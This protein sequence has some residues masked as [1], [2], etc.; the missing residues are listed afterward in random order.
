MVQDKRALFFNYLFW[1]TGFL[2]P[3]DQPWINYALGLLLLFFILQWLTGKYQIKIQNPL[4]WLPLSYFLLH[5]I[6]MI[7]TQSQYAGWIEIS[8]KS[9]FLI[10]PLLFS[11]NAISREMIRTFKLFFV[12]GSGIICLYNLLLSFNQYLLHGNMNSFYYVAFS[13][14]MHVQYLTIYLNLAILFIL[15]ILFNTSSQTNKIKKIFWVLLVLFFLINITLLASRLATVVSYVTILFYTVVR[16]ISSPNYIRY[17]VLAALFAASVLIIDYFAFKKINRFEQV[18]IFLNEKTNFVDFSKTEYNSTTLRIPLW[19]NAYEVIQRNPLFGVGTGDVK[20]SLDS[21]YLKNK[22]TYA[23]QNHFNPHNQYLQTGVAFGLTGI[24]LLMLMMLIPLY[25][26]IRNRHYIFIAFQCI[27]LLNMLTESILER[28]A[29]II[30][31][32]L[33]YAIFSSEYV[34]ATIKTVPEQNNT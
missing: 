11:S 2:L 14:G 22:F 20:S 17:S 24:S 5:C 7:Y 28:Q 3:F 6:G 33:F 29:G 1:L 21:M 31:F 4:L 9:S 32:C 34:A 10:F 16:I 25:Y 30:L 19:I 8:A 18:E 23:H 26:A 12:F 27:F 13:K 15:E